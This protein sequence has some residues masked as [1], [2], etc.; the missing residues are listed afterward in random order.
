[1]AIQMTDPAYLQVGDW[2]APFG[3]KRQYMIGRVFKIHGECLV[4]E[5][6][7]HWET[8]GWNGFWPEHLVVKI[9]E[10]EAAIW[11]LEN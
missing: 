4:R 10:E 7:V 9:S 5:V 2:V 8:D 6:L 11:L 3:S 1:M